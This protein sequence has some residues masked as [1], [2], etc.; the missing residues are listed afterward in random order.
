[1]SKMPQRVQKGCFKDY[2]PQKQ[3][4]KKVLPLI[5]KLLS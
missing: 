2:L 5:G 4:K 1:M 3:G